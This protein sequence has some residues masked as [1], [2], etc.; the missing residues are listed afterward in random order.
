MDTQ[1]VTMTPKN[2]KNN[3]KYNKNF[4]I[5]TLL[6]IILVLSIF[7]TICLNIKKTKTIINPYINNTKTNTYSLRKKN[8]IGCFNTG[9]MNITNTRKLNIFGKDDRV[10]PDISK[11]PAS[12]VGLLEFPVITKNGEILDEL[13][14]CTATLISR[15]L[16]L[17]NK[18]CTGIENLQN[19]DIPDKYWT[20]LT[21]YIGHSADG[22]YLAKT[23]LVRMIHPIG[24]LNIPNN[25]WAIYQLD[26]A[27]GDWYGNLGIKMT[28]TGYFVLDKL[29]TMLGYS[30]DLNGNM[31]AHYYCQSKG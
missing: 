25:D 20:K 31:G 26:I 7:T 21:F 14:I 6:L 17:T 19:G 12:T 8:C 30:G 27:L 16:I 1:F 24:S 18:H 28:T 23:S 13:S 9:K 2:N 15:D 11:Y 29:G 22:S 3:D 4:L 5:I 10:L